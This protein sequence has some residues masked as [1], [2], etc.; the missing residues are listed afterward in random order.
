MI[1]R[2]ESERSFV[3]TRLAALFNDDIKR[4]LISNR[5]HRRHAREGGYPD[6]KTTF[7]D[8]I[9]IGKRCLFKRKTLLQKQIWRK[10]DVEVSEKRSE[11]ENKYN[12]SFAGGLILQFVF[13]PTLYQHRRR[14]LHQ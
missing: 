5:Y 13:R 4:Q 6:F 3:L 11:R 10:N 12:L 7:D 2:R 8:F 9:Q 1:S 14:P